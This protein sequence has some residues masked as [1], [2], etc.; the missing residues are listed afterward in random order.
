MSCSEQGSRGK[1]ACVDVEATCRQLAAELIG[2]RSHEIAFVASTARGLDAVHS[3]LSTGNPEIVFRDAEFPTTTF[4]A[5]RLGK[6][7]GYRRVVRG[8]GGEMP[9]ERY[10]AQIDDRTKLVV[11]NLVSYKMGYKID[12]SPLAAMA[13]AR[14]PLL[15][16][17]A[18][19]GLGAV[20][21]CCSE[22]D[23]LCAGTFKWLL[24]SHG[25]AML[26]V[27]EALARRLELSSVGYR[28]VVEIFPP[29]PFNFCELQPTRDGTRRTRP[30]TL[31]CSSL[32]TRS[33]FASRCICTTPGTTWR[34]S[35]TR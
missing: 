15:F 25:A 8:R 20:P 17:D 22:T 19:Q 34:P 35:F 16:A 5:V 24:G 10:E 14:D 21:V 13:H 2:A 7:G 32:R 33:G 6:R 29:E 11:A 28:S 12:V 9:L 27:R 1:A 31:R 30:I 23:F 26:Y 4:A 18:I 3:S